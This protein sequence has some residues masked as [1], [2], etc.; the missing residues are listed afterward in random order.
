MQ[1]GEGVAFGSL[2]IGFLGFILKVSADEAGKRSRTFQRIDEVKKDMTARIDDAQKNIE[3]KLQS[4][5]ICTIRNDRIDE[6][7]QEI[8]MDLKSLLRKNGII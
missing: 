3:Q 7:L 5:E 2:V 4:K 8:K 1:I 6:T